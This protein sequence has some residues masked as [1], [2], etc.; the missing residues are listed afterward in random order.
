MRA[1]PAHKDLRRFQDRLTSAEFYP[2]GKVSWAKV[3]KEIK[4]SIGKAVAEDADPAGVLG[5]IQRRAEAQDS[6]A[7]A[8]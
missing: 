1:D 6:A 5:A 4:R 3:S 2:V 8:R 7:K